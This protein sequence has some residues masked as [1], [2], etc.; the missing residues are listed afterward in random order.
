MRWESVQTRVRST[1]RS[2]KSRTSRP[3]AQGYAPTWRTRPC[4]Y[5]AVRLGARIWCASRRREMKDWL[6]RLVNARVHRGFA[7]NAE[8]RRKP[9]DVHRSARS[10]PR[11]ESL[12]AVRPFGVGRSRGLYQA[13]R[14]RCRGFAAPSLPTATCLLVGD[15]RIGS[16]VR[17]VSNIPNAEA[18]S[19]RDLDLGGEGCARCARNSEAQ[20][21]ETA[22]RSPP[23]ETAEE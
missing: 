5:K 2:A 18:Q 16:A 7:D 20:Q 8:N 1:G 10:L 11:S 12:S 17:R 4:A 3:R 14:G 23:S 22:G 13:Q 15:R 19:H 9:D 6:E 21:K